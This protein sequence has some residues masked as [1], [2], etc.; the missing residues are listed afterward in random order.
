LAQATQLEV[1][2]GEDGNKPKRI[3][4]RTY[5]HICA[6]VAEVEEMKYAVFCVSALAI[7]WRIGT[8]L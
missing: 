1:K 2:L 6:Q 7:L 4:S 5:E 8:N 3:W